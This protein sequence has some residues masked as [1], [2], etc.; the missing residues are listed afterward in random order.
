M[1]L[2][3]NIGTDDDPQSIYRLAT[4]RL[5][6]GPATADCH[7]FFAQIGERGEGHVDQ[8]VR[9]SSLKPVRA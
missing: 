3:I 4:M 5:P 1:E 2:S 6:W 8:G 7:G 9:H